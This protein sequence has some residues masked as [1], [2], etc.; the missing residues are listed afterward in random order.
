MIQSLDPNATLH[1]EIERGA[2]R[3]IC[4]YSMVLSVF[5]QQ[6]VTLRCMEEREPSLHCLLLISNHL[7]APK[8]E[9]VLGVVIVIQE[10]DSTKENTIGM[11]VTKGCILRRIV[12]A[13]AVTEVFK[14]RNY[15]RFYRTDL[16]EDRKP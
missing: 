11:R 2:H 16:N 9:I 3:R 10:C 5:Y 15:V 1:P 6:C 7:E 14:T 4:L 8:L 13:T 12:L